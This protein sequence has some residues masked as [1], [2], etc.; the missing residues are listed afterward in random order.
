MLEQLRP[1]NAALQLDQTARTIE[2]KHS[3]EPADVDEDA[4][5]G[6]GLPAHGVTAAGDADGAVLLARCA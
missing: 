2:R 3:I 6:K 4:A 1:L 5:L